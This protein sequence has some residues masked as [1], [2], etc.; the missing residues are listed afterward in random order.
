MP[1]E[2]R[3]QSLVDEAIERGVS[4]WI[5][6]P[7]VDGFKVKVGYLGKEEVLKITDSSK[8][9]EWRKHQREEKVDRVKLTRKWA[10]KGILDW[11][12]LTLKKLSEFFPITVK[13]EDDNKDVPCTP[14]NK[15]AL[16]TNSTDFDIWLT[17]VSTSPEYFVEQLKKREGQADELKK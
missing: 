10:D 7:D 1:D 12:G 13:A 14:E 8:E 9:V 16:L 11:K 4:A 2:I 15:Y 5:E 3:I 17:R 6:Y